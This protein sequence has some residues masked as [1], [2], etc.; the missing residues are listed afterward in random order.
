MFKLHDL[1]NERYDIVRPLGQGAMGVVYLATDL[2]TGGDVAVK[3][4]ILPPS[5]HKV[6][7]YR[8]FQVMSQLQHPHVI[9][10]MAA[11]EHEG[12]PYLVMAY[13]A[14][15]TLFEHFA[16][17]PADVLALAARVSL[18]CQIADA[19]SYI[20][21][22]GI[23]HRDITPDNV[24]LEGEHSF[25]MDFGLAKARDAQWQ[26]LTRAGDILGTAA[27]MSPEQIQG[28]TL[29]TRS[30][31]YALGCL[32]YWLCTNQ[33][34]F[35]GKTLPELVGAHVEQPPEVPSSIN[36]LIPAE[37]DALILRL[38]AKD[39]TARYQR[40]DDVLFALRA[41]RR[42]LETLTR[43][44]LTRETLTRETLTSETLVYQRQE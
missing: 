29:D 5:E 11:G 38:L 22:L 37:L 40:A 19:L 27:Y 16:L 42:S 24:M 26:M 13:V 20:H 10:V 32:L 15:S 8:E 23:L 18:A 34:P 17:P 41:C 36:P 35:A 28:R 39:P 33:A 43:E 3:A 9:N 31:L 2:V 30:D 44:T 12:V 1:I 7:F 14:G 4:L 25:L 6:R 21:S